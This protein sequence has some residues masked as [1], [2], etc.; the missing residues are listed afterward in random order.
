M[1]ESRWIPERFG[2]P[3]EFANSLGRGFSLEGEMRSI[4]VVFLHPVFQ[5][6]N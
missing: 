6:E 1:F 3:S 4:L 5:F 2:W